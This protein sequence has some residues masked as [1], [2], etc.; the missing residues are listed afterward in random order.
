MRGKP[1]KH[2][3][4][5]AHPCEART[6]AAGRKPFAHAA[7]H[8]RGQHHRERVQHRGEDHHPERGAERQEHP[9]DAERRH[10]DRGADQE[11]EHQHQR[12][13]E[14]PAEDHARH[15]VRAVDQPLQRG[16][17]GALHLAENRSRARAVPADP[18]GEHRFQPDRVLAQQASQLVAQF[19]LADTAAAELKKLKDL[20][21]AQQSTLESYLHRKKSS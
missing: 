8:K 18:V 20:R 12:Q 21:A 14:R 2:P 16:R 5:P 15:A 19:H 13:R 3:K 1:L 10:H 4:Q 6:T 11:R 17:A 7:V 9:G